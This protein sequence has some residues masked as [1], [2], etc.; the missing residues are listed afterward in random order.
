VV[1]GGLV[2][3]AVGYAV[4]ALHADAR[5]YRPG[6][7]EIGAAIGGLVGGSLLGSLLPVERDAPLA[8]HG[9]P[10]AAWRRARIVRALRSAYLGPL[11]LPSGAGLGIA[12]AM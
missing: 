6:P 8:S 9:A 11:A 10:L 12:G 1:I 7:G 3:I 4:P 2:G 5:P